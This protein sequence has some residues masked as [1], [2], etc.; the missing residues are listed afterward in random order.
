MVVMTTRVKAILITHL[1][2]RA[3]GLA[4]TLFT[5]ITIVAFTARDSVKIIVL[6]LRFIRNF[7]LFDVMTD[8]LERHINKVNNLI[9]LA[10]R[11]AFG[12]LHDVIN[13]VKILAFG[14]ANK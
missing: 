3:D 6:R 10:K 14:L 12:S 8:I 5:V 9:S 4:N 1:A 7:I 2:S 13:K 11:E